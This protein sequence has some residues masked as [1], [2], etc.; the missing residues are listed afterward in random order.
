MPTL[1]AGNHTITVDESDFK[2]LQGKRLAYH[3]GS[4]PSLYDPV[5]RRTVSIARYLLGLKE[6]DS[7]AVWMRDGDSTNLT[8]ANIQVVS[9]AR[10]QV[11]LGARSRGR[12]DPSSSERMRDPARNPARKGKTGPTGVYQLPNGK[13]QARFLAPGTRSAKS[14]GCFATEEEAARAHDRARERAGLEPVNFPPE[15]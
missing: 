1:T 9:R 10:K 12:K 14:L 8:R 13:Y 6:G 5:R 2:R 15:F 3:K 4:S 11:L 7:R